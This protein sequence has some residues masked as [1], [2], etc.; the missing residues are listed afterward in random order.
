MNELKRMNNVVMENIDND[1]PLVSIIVITYNS[2]KYV[3]ETLNSAKEQTYR[4]IELIITDDG[5]KDNT[6]Q[7]V[8]TWLSDNHNR[9]RKSVIV[10]SEINTGT[11]KNCNRGLKA[12][13]GEW[14]KIIA[15][16]DILMP[17]CIES[18]LSFSVSK[19]SL[20]STSA[21]NEFCDDNLPVR[22][23]KTIYLEQMRFFSKKKE[24]QFQSYLRNSVFLNSPALFI[25]KELFEK[26]GY[27]D[28]SLKILEDT[29]FI[30]KTLR[31]GFNIYYNEIPTVRYRTNQKTDHRIDGQISDSFICFNKYQ[32][33][34]LSKYKVYDY[35]IRYDFFLF[36]QRRISNSII[37]RFI[38]KNLI[39]F[40]DFIYIKKKIAE[41]LYN[42]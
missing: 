26:V 10:R 7:I 42:H 21:M 13:E 40:T 35:L 11:P 4:N 25:K 41:R 37:S 34:Y 8:E 14:I 6:V 29:P 38:L 23:S 17:H 1:K 22:L 31:A 3:L 30:L 2:A 19:G 27:Y 32:L 15:G 33:P 20:I 39:K 9:F 28:E 36:Y 24:E 16:D 12:S 5:S 18:M